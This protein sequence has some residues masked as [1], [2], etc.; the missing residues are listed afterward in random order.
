V[1]ALS[2][3]KAVRVAVIEDGWLGARY[4][5][6]AAWLTPLPMRYFHGQVPT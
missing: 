2:S 6:L 3:G 4:D 1:I 5:V